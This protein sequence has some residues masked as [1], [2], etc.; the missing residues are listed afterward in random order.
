MK[1]HI[2]SFLLKNSSL[3]SFRPEGR[4][5]KTPFLEKGI[6]HLA[7]RVKIAYFQWESASRE[8][9]FQKIDARIKLLFST[10]FLIIVSLKK[11][12]FS[13][14]LIGL[15]IISLMTLSRLNLLRLYRRILFFGIVFGF[16]VALPSAINLFRGGEV[17]FSLFSLS[18]PYE[19]WIYSIPETI[20]VTKEGLYG[21]AMLTLRVINSLSITF[22]LLYT[23]PFA[24]IIRALKLFRIPDTF[25]IVITLAYKYL[26]L[27]SKTAEEMHLAKKSRLLKEVNPQGARRWIAGRMALLFRKSRLRAEEVF[28]AMLCRGFSDSVKIYK[29]VRMRPRD[30][31]AGLS[32]FLIGLLLLWI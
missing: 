18:R 20:A 23:T 22:L 2:P 7:E 13:E 29:P 16:I 12:I 1:D 5:L 3:D 4:S 27:F 31:A 28:N 25:L 8:G 14:F 15:S 26:F 30:W 6:H 19:L 32:L 11:D 24:E 17:L 9:L 10:F 21:M